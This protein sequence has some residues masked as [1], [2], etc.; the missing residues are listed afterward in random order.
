MAK[1]KINTTDIINSSTKASSVRAGVAA[2][3]YGISSTRWKTDSQILG[4]NGIDG[5]LNGVQE[6]VE[7]IEK[8][9][10]TIYQTVDNGAIKY[11]NTETW[12][13][14]LGAMLGGM[15]GKRGSSG[16]QNPY[17]VYFDGGNP[18]KNGAVSVNSE[19]GIQK[20][21]S[22]S[23]G[24]ASA[25]ASA[26]KLDGK[27]TAT[28]SASASVAEGTVGYNAES[29][30]FTFAGMGTVLGAEAS[31]AAGYDVTGGNLG[32]LAKAEASAY[33][34]K[35]EIE[36]KNLW[37]LEKFKATGEVL[38]ISAEGTGYAV[39]MQDGNFRPAVGTEGEASAAVA[40]GEA[41]ET[42]GLDGFNVKG[43]VEGYVVGASAEAEAKVGWAQNDDG[44]SVFGVSANAGAE[45]YLAKGEVS[46]GFTIFGVEVIGT[47]GGGVGGG[48]LSAGAG[49][50][51]ESLELSAGIGALIGV[52]VEIEIDWSDFKLWEDE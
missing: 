38:S 2:V 11:Q 33:G 35:G 7:Q 20:E 5:R 24:N 37:G 16:N 30:R 10:L 14:N 6:Q 3:S 49:I 4:R 46:G 51:T 1:I 23:I 17:G 22:G 26:E 52:D 43:K 15:N 32:A 9:I 19:R 31:A 34:L 45:A 42:F 44:E 50:T 8:D 48:E 25:E 41:E 39:L 36:S 21:K 27:A 47:I 29:G 40:K 12:V 18:D 13:V 28:A